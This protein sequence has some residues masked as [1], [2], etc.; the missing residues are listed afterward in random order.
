[1]AVLFVSHSS[2]DDRLPPHW[3]PG[4]APMASR[5]SSSIIQASRAAPNGARNCGRPPGLA[6][7]SSASSPRIGWRR[8]NASTSS[9]RLGTWASASSHCFSC[10]PFRTSARKQRSGSRR[11]VQRIKASISILASSRTASSGP[12]CRRERCKSLQGGLRAAGALSRVGLDPEA[13]EIDRKLRPTPFPGLDLVWRRRRRRGAVLRPQPRDRPGAW[14][15]CGRCV[16]PPSGGH[17]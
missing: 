15:L 11:S 7:S 9:A 1:M 4:C 3:K 12:R 10:R 5:T 17:L 13:F 16:P 6:A 14:M 8:T 2:A